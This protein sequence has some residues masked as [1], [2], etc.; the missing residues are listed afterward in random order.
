MSVA[1]GYLPPSPTLLHNSVSEKG[2]RSQKFFFE[3]L[4]L[5]PP[6]TAKVG[7]V[8]PRDI[9]SDQVVV[10]SFLVYF[11]FILYI[12]LSCVFSFACNILVLYQ[13]INRQKGFKM[14]GEDNTT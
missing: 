3:L 14:L 1:Y 11:N 6:V 4:E 5:Y 13:A 10:L 7:S 9:H 12:Y 8:Y 2:K